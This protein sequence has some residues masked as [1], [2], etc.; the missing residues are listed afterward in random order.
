MVSIKPTLGMHVIGLKVK[1]AKKPV[2]VH[3]S[4]DGKLALVNGYRF[5]E[6]LKVTSA[7]RNFAMCLR[8]AGM[9][10]VGSSRDKATI[11]LLKEVGSYGGKVFID[12]ARAPANC[13]RYGNK[14]PLVLFRK[15]RF[16]GFRPREF[17]AALTSCGPFAKAMEVALQGT[18]GSDKKTNKAAKGPTPSEDS[19]AH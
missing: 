14:L 6:R 9:R 17:L 3:V 16:E 5:Q 19:H 18:S 1:G 15:D 12:C 8:L 13:K 7:E 2:A 11:K 10:I 4:A